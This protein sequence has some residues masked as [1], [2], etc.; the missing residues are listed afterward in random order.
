[1]SGSTPQPRRR[2]RPHGLQAAAPWLFGLTLLLAWAL[3]VAVAAPPPYMLPAPLAVAERLGT[4]LGSPVFWPAVR[5]T[6]AEAVGG[7]LLGTAV[8]LPLAVAI[9]RSRLLN[10]AIT[11]F[12]GATQAI[13]AI[14]IAPLL[15]IWVGYGI[16]PI[17]LL[18]A[19][20]VFFPILVS[21]VVGLRH[22]DHHVVDAA[23]MDG[24]G[25]FAL[26][27]HIEFPLALPTVL[28]GLRNGFA[29]AVTGAVVGEMVMG[30]SGLGQL[31]TIQRDA[32]DTAGMF[33]TIVVLCAMASALYG[34]ILL[35][36]RR[37]RTVASLLP[38]DRP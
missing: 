15:A 33:A 10:A 24:A 17:I 7:S 25:S 29:L 34:L 13:P 23:R 9:H 38:T 2:V 31:L 19:L 35:I 12:L 30:G 20:M 14:A 36:E 4:A 11:P 27:R 5:E 21:A 37:S 26:L 3:V 32:V 8:A 1:M 16:G 6:F 28:A 22:V 18:C